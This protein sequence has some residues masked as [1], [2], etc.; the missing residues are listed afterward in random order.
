MRAAGNNTRVGE[1]VRV[2]D[3]AA[4]PDRDGAV[5]VVPENIALAVGVEVAARV[6]GNS[7]GAGDIDLER[8]GAGRI[9]GGVRDCEEEA[10]RRHAAGGLMIADKAIVNVGL[11]K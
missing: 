3:L 8:R 5:I 7:G 10:V 4:I 11:G 1:P 9:T 6:T 2:A